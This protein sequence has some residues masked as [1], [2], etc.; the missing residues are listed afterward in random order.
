MRAK[1]LHVGV[2][3]RVLGERGVGRYL[4]SLLQALAAIKGPQRYT[5]FVNSKSRAELAP[6]DPRF[7]VVNLG[8]VNPAVAEQSLIP[9]LALRSPMD[10]LFYPDN[11]GAIAPGLPMVL[12]LHDGM[13][14]RPISEAV[15]RPTLRQR[16]QDAYRKFVVPRAAR[17]AAR[18]ITVS[19]FSAR[20][21]A[22]SLGLGPSLHVV[23]NALGP[24]FERPL[25]QAAVKAELRALGIQGPFFFCSGASDRRKNI[26]RLIRALALS[27]LEQMQLVVSSLRPGEKE[28]TDYEAVV[29]DCG[30]GERVKFLGF[31]SE[32]QLKALYQGASAYVF[33]SLWEGFGLPILE[34]YALGCPVLAS[35]AGALPEVGGRA[36]LYAD[37]LSEASLAQGL[38]GVLKL[39]RAAFK[40]AAAGELRR[41]SWA[42]SARQTLKLF[43]EAA[44]P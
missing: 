38:R 8:R 32:A 26:S 14:Q 12:A 28:T 29:K 22:A 24:G 13:W 31:V 43:Y 16:L 11:S 21:L 9:R 4:S 19:Q 34:A 2:D 37:P 17:R 10:L 3:A 5:L 41:Y 44:N 6:Q 23:P 25:P 42:E 20:E 36:A 40:K 39:R 15:F 33:P 30:L 7:E 1:A 35:S 18:V 27:G